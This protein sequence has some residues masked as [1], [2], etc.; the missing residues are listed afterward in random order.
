M[1]A[2]IDDTSRFS[3]G[4]AVTPGFAVTKVQPGDLIRSELMNGIVDWLNSLEARMTALQAST[5]VGSRVTITSITGTAVPIRVGMRVTVRGTGFLQPAVLNA[6]N[7]SG[8]PVASFIDGTDTFLTFDMPTVAGLSTSGS[9][10]AVF[11]GNSNGSA[12]LPFTLAPALVVPTG[13]TEA[14]YA[15]APVLTVSQPNITAGQSYN[16]TYRITSF[17]S[18]DTTYQIQASIT[19]ATGWTVQPLQE[20]DDSPNTGIRLAAGS[21]M[22]ALVRVRVTVGS[23]VGTLN[24]TALATGV[25]QVTPGVAP[26]LLI[27]PLA[28]PPTPET[29]ARV[30]LRAPVPAANGKIPFTRGQDGGVGFTVAVTQKGVYQV[31][32]A[33][34][35]ATGWSLV[36]QDATTFEVKTDPAANSSA[37]QNINVIFNP[38][39]T[40]TDTDLVFSVTRGSDINVQYAIPVSVV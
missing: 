21:G 32:A 40:A 23:G 3:A 9:P 2:S 4:F 16:F 20:N 11:V 7:V 18:H 19:G 25:T 39:A 12:S 1:A 13:R 15:I 29:R 35:A 38:G 27:T 34:R 14:V 30:S 28:P 36:A 6:V 22:S 17:V 33:M 24:V 5:P 10:A 26:A 31:S 37:S 8:S